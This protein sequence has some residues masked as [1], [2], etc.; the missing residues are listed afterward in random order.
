MATILEGGVQRSGNR[1]RINAQLIRA[2]RDEHIWADTFDRELTAGNVFEIQSEI[3]RAIADALRATLTED[4][5]R[6]LAAVPTN[7]IDA[8]DRYF[9]GRQLLEQRTRESLDAA[10]RYFEQVTELDP[11]FALGWSGIADAYMLMPEYDPFVDRS[12]VDKRRAKAAIEKGSLDRARPA[13]SQGIAG[14]V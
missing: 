7:N 10:V 8:L 5:E 9:I 14:L 12:M 1:I 2:D 4:D 3:A 13:R 11:D 6:R